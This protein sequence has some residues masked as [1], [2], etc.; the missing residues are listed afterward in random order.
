MHLIG[1]KSSH[2]FFCLFGVFFGGKSNC[3]SLCRCR[4]AVGCAWGGHGQGEGSTGVAL[5]LAPRGTHKHVFSQRN[6]KVRSVMIC[7][8][9]RKLKMVKNGCG[10]IFVSI[11]EEYKIWISLAGIM[12]WFLASRSVLCIYTIYFNPLYNLIFFWIIM[13]K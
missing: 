1:P 7:W 2:W 10:L 3:R 8:Q 11:E 6:V 4:G 12:G 5:P 9:A 13:C